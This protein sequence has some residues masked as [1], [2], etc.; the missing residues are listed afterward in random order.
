MRAISGRS[1]DGVSK[2]MRTLTGIAD[3]APAVRTA[4]PHYAPA[5][6]ITAL[7]YQQLSSALCSSS[8]R[9][10]IRRGARGHA[11]PKI[12]ARHRARL[13]PCTHTH[14]SPRHSRLFA[15]SAVRR[16]LA[17][18]ARQPC[19][20][21]RGY[22]L[23]LRSG[24]RTLRVVAVRTLSRGRASATAWK[25]HHAGRLLLAPPA[26]HASGPSEICAPAQV[27]TRA[28]AIVSSGPGERL[29][30]TFPTWPLGTNITRES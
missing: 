24:L 18:R 25:P 11:R 14:T 9:Q 26:G 23:T 7:T 10:A 16:R 13:H 28:A 21:P 15:P 3:T 29:A 30:S 1:A 4:H 19:A 17:L 5:P 20:R 12:H 8:P 27:G 22:I 6:S 2:R